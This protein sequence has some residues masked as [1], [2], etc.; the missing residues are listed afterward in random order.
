MVLR[1]IELWAVID[2]FKHE[3]RFGNDSFIFT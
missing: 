3:M 2:R 1:K